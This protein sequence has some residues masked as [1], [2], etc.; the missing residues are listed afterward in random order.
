MDWRCRSGRHEEFP[1]APEFAIARKQA[2]SAL[3]KRSP[4]WR[5][6]LAV[7]KTRAS[8]DR[9]LPIYYCIHIDAIRGHQAMPIQRG[10]RPQPE[11]YERERAA[12][13]ICRNPNR[14]RTQLAATTAPIN[15]PMIPRTA[16]S[17][18]VRYKF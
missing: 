14:P 17:L 13:M 5:A 3:E 18:P 1:E 7:A 15:A 9:G 2:R 6:G 12:R 10:P 8:S 11:S 4:W 16:A